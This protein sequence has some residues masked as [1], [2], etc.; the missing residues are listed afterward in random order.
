[1]QV[2]YEPYAGTLVQP[3]HILHTE[4]AIV[5]LQRQATTRHRRAPLVAAGEASPDRSAIAIDA[6]NVDDHHRLV[7]QSHGLQYRSLDL[8]VGGGAP[9]KALV[10]CAEHDVLGRVKG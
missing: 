6:T 10:R 4:T 8:N 9:G 5:V 2:E 3:Q 7:P 1:M